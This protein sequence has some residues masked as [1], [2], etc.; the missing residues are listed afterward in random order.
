MFLSIVISVY[1]EEQSLQ[2]LYHEI[3]KV[4]ILCSET[5]KDFYHEIVFIND[6]SKDKSDRILSEIRENDDSVRLISFSKNFGHEAAMFAG[7]SNSKGD[8]I[9]CMDA[10]LQHPPSKIVEMLKC[11]YNGYE[12]VC[13]KRVANRGSGYFRTILTKSFYKLI[14]RISSMEIEHNT[15]DFFLLTKSVAKV[16]TSVF[17]ERTLFLRGLL[18]NI[19]F[20][21]ITLEFIAP[22]R[23]AGKSKYT[24]AKLFS[25]SFM[26]IASLSKTPLYLG[27]FTGVATGTLSFIVII[28]T[29]VM[30]FRGQTPPGYTTIVVLIGFLFSIAFFLIG[31]I[32]YYLGIVVTEVKKRPLYIERNECDEDN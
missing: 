3:T 30:K 12:I 23:F 31:I 13:M 20:K 14:N 5:F 22:E 28:Y 26:A 1:N 11:F 29:V 32:G 2:A 16:I 25:L 27:L 15:T 6:G 21:K 9:I 4:L 17:P 7:I 10:D 18:Q 8:V 24:V 19:G